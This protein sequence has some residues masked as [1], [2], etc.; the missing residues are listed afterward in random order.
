MA[1]ISSTYD[2]LERAENAGAGDSPLCAELI[3]D[4]ARQV[5]SCISCWVIG[6]ALDIVQGSGKGAAAGRA[7]L[8]Q[9]EPGSGSRFAGMLL[10]ILSHSITSDAQAALFE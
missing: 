1:A 10:P 9:W 7:V 8:E 5:D 3:Q 6:R 2:L 4:E